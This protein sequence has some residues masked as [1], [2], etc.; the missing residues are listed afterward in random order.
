MTD[1]NGEANIE[2]PLHA[3]DKLKPAL[4]FQ[5]MSHTFTTIESSFKCSQA[6]SLR[7]LDLPNNVNSGQF[8]IDIDHQFSRAQLLSEDKYNPPHES[9]NNDDL[10]FIIKRENE[11]RVFFIN[12]ESFWQKLKSKRGPDDSSSHHSSSYNQFNLNDKNSLSYEEEVIGQRKK[13]L[14][15]GTEEVEQPFENKCASG[16]GE[17]EQK[18]N[19]IFNTVPSS[20]QI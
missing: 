15:E 11:K 2:A 12:T 7:E 13:S 9:Y 20:A 10:M 17:F 14:Q 8:N 18:D 3:S 16:S 1:F 4:E 6:G 5:G 19:G